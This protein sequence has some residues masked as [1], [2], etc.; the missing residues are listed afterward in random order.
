MV[1]VG[2]DIELQLLSL[3]RY[4]E[5]GAAIEWCVHTSAVPHSSLEIRHRLLHLIPGRWSIY[6]SQFFSLSD[7]LTLCNYTIPPLPCRLCASRRCCFR[8]SFI[9]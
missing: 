8:R 5:F 6:E 7:S 1:L 9:A 3:Q 4:T 2:F